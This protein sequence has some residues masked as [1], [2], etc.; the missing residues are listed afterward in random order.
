[1]AVERELDLDHHELHYIK[2]LQ[3]AKFKKKLKNEFGK[4]C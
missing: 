3:Q 1:M 4:K 2:L